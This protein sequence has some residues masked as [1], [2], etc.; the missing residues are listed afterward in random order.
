MQPTA[1]QQKA[2]E[3]FK[4]G[5][6]LVI[7]A[8]AGTGKTSTL[9]LLAESTPRRGQY[10]AFNRAIVREAEAKMPP[11]V[12]CKTAHG[13]A[14]ATVGRNFQHRL[15]GSRMRSTE[16]AHRL[17]LDPVQVTYRDERKV[18]TAPYLAGLTMRAIA[19]F[20]QSADLEPGR[21]HVPY[22]KG[23]DDPIQ[24]PGGFEN[25]RL[26][27]DVL[28]PVMRRAWRDLQDLRGQLPY[29][30]D[31]YLK[32]WQLQGPRI[33][34]DFILFDEAQDA[35]PVMTAIVTAQRD[36]QLVWVGD[37]QQ[38]IY[39]FTGAVNAMQQVGAEQTA[40]LTQSWRFG[41]EIAS[42]ANLVLA[43]LEAPL[44][45]T[46]T[47]SIRSRVDR[48]AEPRAILCRTNA[49]AVQEVL[50]AL[51]AGRRVHLVGGAGDVVRFAE[52]ALDLQAGRPT[53]H[54]ELA[55]FTDWREVLAYVDEDEQGGDL[56]LLTNLVEQFGAAKIIDALG[57]QV[58][59]RDA[60][61]V[62]S[63]AHKSKGREWTSVRLGPDFPDEPN[64]QE[65]RLLYVAVTRAREQLDI[66]SV[67]F[68]DSLTPGR[69]TS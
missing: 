10:V 42:V 25:N 9:K 2:I 27:R 4:T 59:E 62:V 38:Q 22:I 47:D 24:R 6:S 46:G 66:S 13:L 8:G 60:D 21:Q 40:Y 28:E 7:E 44:R 55:C 3:L 31:H 16:L 50:T 64:E 36:A 30:H 5:R 23:I 17:G 58:D 61:L 37:S 32:A 49:C 52:A 11:T 63:T 35:N 15:N 65:M 39:E 57:N 56:K 53:Q 33:R 29:T 19:K 67:G 18:L 1:E 34:A 51:E 54:P 12:R 69:L 45:V 41:P 20:C 14:F 68:L 26:I 43:Q 48:I